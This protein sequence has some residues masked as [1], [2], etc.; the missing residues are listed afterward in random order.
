M[1]LSDR[2]RSK[3]LFNIRKRTH[4]S[5]SYIILVKMAL[6]LSCFLM[7]SY[8]YVLNSPWYHL[9][10]I[11]GLYLFMISPS[12][13]HSMY[14]ITSIQ[15][16]VKEM[17]WFKLKGTT[18]KC[19][20]MSFIILSIP[21]LVFALVFVPKGVFFY[22]LFST[23]TIYQHIQ[24]CRTKRYG[25]GKVT[26]YD[27]LLTAILS[28]LSSFVPS[29]NFTLLTL[30][31]QILFWNYYLAVFIFGIVLTRIIIKI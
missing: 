29:L 3:M 17:E 7:N 19:L 13:I 30:K 2:I 26:L 31:Q 21:I 12:I 23:V 18:A 16:Q 1:P 15:R 8:Y 25:F 22:F 6:L 27:L 4:V 14:F 28:L 20:T 10:W 5:M 9:F 24:A 11:Y